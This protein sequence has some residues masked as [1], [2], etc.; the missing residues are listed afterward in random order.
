MT[1]IEKIENGYKV[2]ML[3]KDPNLARDHN[4]YVAVGISTEGVQMKN[5]AIIACQGEPATHHVETYWSNGA[6]TAEIKKI[7]SADMVVPGSQKFNYN[8]STITCEFV[9]KPSF[10]I[11]FEH[12]QAKSFDLDKKK[13]KI[14]MA[15]GLYDDNK[16]TE[17]KL[18]YHKTDRRIS[19]DYVSLSLKEIN[20][21]P[22]NKDKDKHKGD[23]NSSCVLPL[24]SLSTMALLFTGVITKFLNYY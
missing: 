4:S 14:L 24:P 17:I 13:Y 21:A 16:P 12:S 7:N 18:S 11:N 15:V 2:K 8:E 23:K 20:D 3:Y 5:V 6:S 1:Q 19:S 22:D 10:T 9:L